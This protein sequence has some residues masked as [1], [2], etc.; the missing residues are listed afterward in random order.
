[1]VTDTVMARLLGAWC[2]MLVGCSGDTAH[3]VPAAAPVAVCAEA[4]RGDWPEGVEVVVP[5]EASLPCR[6]ELDTLT[7]RRYSPAE[8]DSLDLFRVRAED[9]HGNLYVQGYQPGVVTI[10]SP[11]GERIGRFGQEG[12]GPGEL[13]SG[14]FNVHVTALDSIY[15]Q[16][17]RFRW[18]VWT[19]EHQ[20]VRSMALGVIPAGPMAR[21][22]LSGGGMIT[23]SPGGSTTSLQLVDAAGHLVAGLGDT[24]PTRGSL[25]RRAVTCGAENT[26]WAFPDPGRPDYRIERWDSTGRLR[27]AVIRRTESFEAGPPQTSREVMTSRPVSAVKQVVESSPG[28]VF[29]VVSGADSDWA[30]AARSERLPPVGQ[31]LDVRYE[32]IDAVGG[33]LLGV[34]W[35][36]DPATL[37][38]A[39]I[40]PSGRSYQIVATDDGGAM[41]MAYA[42]HLRPVGYAK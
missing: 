21:C 15:I 30:P 22:V 24:D 39:M 35:V 16:N 31:L 42:L 20:F 7:V 33:R 1:M 41:L 13:P 11:T 18:N 28:L 40:M 6:I 9:R 25:P 37:P 10:L 23:A 3:P 27:R 34:L 5:D 17:S 2:L 14:A 8:A 19:P 32:A 26:A 36:D 12:P 29:T 4:N 38:N